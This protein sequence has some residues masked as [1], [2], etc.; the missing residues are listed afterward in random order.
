[1]SLKPQLKIS[2][3]DF[4]FKKNNRDQL[5]SFN[6]TDNIFTNLLSKIYDVK[7]VS[8]TEADVLIYST[9]GKTHQLFHGKKIFYT[10]E[11]VLPDFEECDY[12]ISFCH[13]P[14]EPRH[15]RLPQ[16]VFYVKDINEL[17]KSGKTNWTSLLKNKTKFA[18]FIVSNPR[19]PE[20][21]RFFKLLN[22][23]KHVD[24]GGRHFNNL[25]RIIDNKLEFIKG[26]KFTLAFEN[27]SSPGYTTEKIVEAM[28]AGSVPIYWGNPNI[29]QDFN[30]KSFIDVS[31]F[32]TFEAAIDH[33]LEVDSN[34]DLYLSYLK[35][36]WFNQNTPPS[37]FKSDEHLDVLKKFIESPWLEH[38]RHYKNR[39]LRD[40]V[41]GTGIPRHLSS[42]KCKLEG[43]LWK[44][45]WR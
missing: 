21:N 24:S 10:S 31:S 37:W 16:Y 2:F 26:Y 35:E 9:F 39:G 11:N 28:L 45:G 1:M 32:S 43:L 36:P 23:R 14:N 38:P 8:L 30:P 27:S 25:G 40:H 5:A 33:I 4:I 13:L 15:Y 17:I 6:P 22:R 34:D 29:A 20:R 41:R 18:N 12:A 19:G 42:L 44:L 3:S 7:I